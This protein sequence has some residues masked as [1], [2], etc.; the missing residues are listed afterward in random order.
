MQALKA[1][2]SWSAELLEGKNGARGRA[3]IGSI[4]P[5]NFA[6]LLVVSAD[7]S[8]DISNTKKIERVMKNAHWVELTYQPEYVRLEK[9][10]STLAASTS[11]PVISSIA[12][13]SLKEGSAS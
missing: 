12:P 6:D 1:A 4:R 2:T 10:V 11:A 3:K 13:S 7:P 9:P 5:G 8:S